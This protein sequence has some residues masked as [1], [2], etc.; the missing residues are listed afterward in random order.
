MISTVPD[1]RN[2]V[3]LEAMVK[4]MMHEPFYRS[5]SQIHEE[6]GLW[7][8]W[9]DQTGSFSDCMPVWN[10]AR[11]VCLIFVGE[12]YSDQRGI[13]HLRAKGHGFASGNAQFLVH[14]YEE[15]GSKF[16]ERLNGWF[17]GVLLDLRE[18]K[19]V[20]FNDRFGLGRIFFCETDR[21]FYFA[22]EAKSLLKVLP[23]LR[24]LDFQSLGELLSC[25]AVL[26]NRSLF[27]GISLMP[28][29]SAWT[30]SLG[31]SI[32]KGSY[33]TRQNWEHQVPLGEREYYEEL[34]ETWSRALPRYFQGEERVG[35]SLTGGV[36]SRMILAWA[37]RP[38]GTLPNYTFGGPFRDCM[39]VKVAREVARI[40]EQPH[41]VIPV[42]QEFFDQ[43]PA[44]AEK[45]VFISDG[46]MDVTG[47][48][49]LY[50]QRVAREIAPVRVTGTNGGEILRRLVAFKPTSFSQ[51][52]LSPEMARSMS[53][54]ARTYAA[55]LQGHQLSFTAFK[56]TPWYMCSKFVV[57]RSQIALRM[58][59]FDND[60]VALSYRAPSILAES[61]GPAL[62]LIGDGNP[63]LKSIGTDRGLAA[64]SIPG[65][66]MAR[67]LFQQFTFKAEY[68]YDYGMPQSLAKLD[69]V[70]APLH[71]ERLF[72]GR[73]K[74]HH[75]RVYYRDQLSRYVKDVLLDPRT[76]NRPYLQGRNLEQMVTGHLRG[77][78]NYT[79]EIHKVLTTE[80]IHRQLLENS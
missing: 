28:G 4:C 42:G 76:R 43:F 62:R 59:Y 23:G 52:L 39:D 20:L 49:D 13:E 54:A 2:R 16:L 79:L 18:R 61:N 40:C 30:F 21:A 7:I 32:R 47:A 58:P 45:T 70:F 9:A 6:L 63:A 27:S 57:E 3:T 38:R 24:R 15:L 80:L 69:H 31:Q 75:F 48:I 67:H 11:D 34:K 77:N 33:F 8:G 60:L 55:E 50:V 53:E 72:L 35:L 65:I 56:Q 71:L 36:D 12:E 74:F 64:R 1:A 29:A 14:L 22:S 17:S 66:T 51:H 68:A 46:C 19:I 10:E 73:H 44:L 25:G 78:R 41:S 26:Q 5:G 37:R